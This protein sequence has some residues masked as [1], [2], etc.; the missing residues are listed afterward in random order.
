M[1]FQ[2]NNLPSVYEMA[3]KADLALRL[4]R[5]GPSGR[6]GCLGWCSARDR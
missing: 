6:W 1:K 2:M 4:G 3:K 5:L